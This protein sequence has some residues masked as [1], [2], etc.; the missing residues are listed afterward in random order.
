MSAWDSIRDAV[1]RVR[2]TLGRQ[3]AIAI[4]TA[5]QRARAQGERVHLT[6]DWRRAFE[7]LGLRNPH[8]GKPWSDK[9]A[10]AA[11]KILA[12][13]TGGGLVARITGH[14]WRLVSDALDALDHRQLELAFDGPGGPNGKPESPP[15]PAPARPSRPPSPP[16]SPRT[17]AR[18]SWLE[19]VIGREP[20][21]AGARDLARLALELGALDGQQAWTLTLT[22]AD[23]AELE[24]AARRFAEGLDVYLVPERSCVGRLHFHGF[25]LATPEQGEALRQRW[26]DAGGGTCDAKPIRDIKRLRFWASYAHKHEA[27]DIPILAT[28]R[29]AEPTEPPKPPAARPDPAPPK[30]RSGRRPLLERARELLA[31]AWRRWGTRRAPP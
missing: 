12:A 8:T 27:D 24:P 9:A 18:A 29:F 19:R 26:L 22:A 10:L 17:R 28:G 13:L 4:V 16:P 11:L 2:C 15:E 25:V 23:V 21:H 31:A 3:V 14:T 7:V 1:L 6:G 20:S 30:G 5:M